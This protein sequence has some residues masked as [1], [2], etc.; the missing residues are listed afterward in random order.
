MEQ[1]WKLTGGAGIGPAGSMPAG[2]HFEAL[3]DIGDPPLEIAF[4]DRILSF[5][6]DDVL[7]VLT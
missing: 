7:Q 1:D 3:P 5:E 2:S 6:F 4:D